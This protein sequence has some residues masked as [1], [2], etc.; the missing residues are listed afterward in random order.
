MLNGNDPRPRAI[1]NNLLVISDP[2]NGGFFPSKRDFS[3]VI[4][5]DDFCRQKIL[6][7]FRKSANPVVPGKK[8]SI[9]FRP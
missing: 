3:E 2:E 1:A 7:I 6:R 4:S 8:H 5:I 9:A